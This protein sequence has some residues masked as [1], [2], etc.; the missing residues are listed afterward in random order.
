MIRDY[1]IGIRTAEQ[2]KIFKRFYR[3]KDVENMEGS[4]LG[5][6]LCRL[7]LENEKGSITVKSQYG[8]G[9][10]VCVMLKNGK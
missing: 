9:S 4:G 1:G 5:L 7:I 3:S 10:E 8:Q 6:Y 2:E